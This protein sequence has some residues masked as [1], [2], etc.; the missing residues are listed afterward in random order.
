[1]QYPLVVILSFG[2]NAL[3]YS[4][5]AEV[6]PGDLAA[7]SKHS[8][9]W[10]EVAGLLAWKALELAIYWFGNFDGEA[11]QGWM[12]VALL[13]S[14]SVRRCVCFVAPIDTADDFALIFLLD[15]SLHVNLHDVC[16][17]D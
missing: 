15:Q 2:F 7:I 9:S 6:T 13:T 14:P 3:M 12:F 5:I 4:F 11:H 17:C 10:A 8:E 16:Q 1:M